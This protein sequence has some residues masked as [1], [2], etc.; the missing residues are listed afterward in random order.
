MKCTKASAN[1]TWGV[2][3][4]RHE[5]KVTLVEHPQA[6]SQV[7]GTNKVILGKLQRCLNRAKGLWAEHLPSIL[8]AYHCSLYQLTYE[9]NAMI[10]VEITKPSHRRDFFDPSKKPSYLRVDLN[11]VEEVKEQACIQQETCKQRVAH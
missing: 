5:H 10:P 3:P 1:S 11:L 8:W 6:N 2:A 7:E 4:W 9:T